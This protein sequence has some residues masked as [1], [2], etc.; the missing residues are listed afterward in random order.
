VKP[1]E[2]FVILPGGFGTLD[3][4]FESLTLIQTGKVLNFPVVLVGANHWRDLVDWTR[5]EL[6]K[7]ELI[8]PEDVRLLH[9]T[10]D[11]EEAV[12]VILDCYER[13]CAEVAVPGVDDPP[14]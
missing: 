6:L 12:R 13:R 9:L 2:G 11:P 10:D 4:L 14:P 5:D 7:G 8:A 3:E 1:S